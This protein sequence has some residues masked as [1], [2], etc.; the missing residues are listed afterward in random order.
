MDYGE[1]HKDIIG[2]FVQSALPD[3]EIPNLRNQTGEYD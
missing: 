1:A 3:F 2:Q